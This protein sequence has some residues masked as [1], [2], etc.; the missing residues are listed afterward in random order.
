MVVQKK[1]IVKKNFLYKLFRFIYNQLQGKKKS[2]DRLSHK[3]LL[4]RLLVHCSR[5]DI[6]KT[7][8]IFGRPQ[9]THDHGYVVQE[10]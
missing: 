3:K 10:V 7:I 9:V 2:I 8:F 6:V 1:L 5:Q 4:L